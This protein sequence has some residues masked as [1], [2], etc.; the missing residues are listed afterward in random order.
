MNAFVR[1]S[2]VSKTWFGQDSGSNV[3]ALHSHLVDENE[4]I[5]S[6]LA[7][8]TFNIMDVDQDSVLLPLSKM[9]VL[10][11]PTS[12]TGRQVNQ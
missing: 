9:A 4:G 3:V 5:M 2:A 12:T 7:N 8:S 1:Y 10:C 6:F 11:A